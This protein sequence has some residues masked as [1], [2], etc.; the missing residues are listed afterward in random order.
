MDMQRENLAAT[1][2][3][4]DMRTHLAECAD[5]VGTARRV[6]GREHN[7]TYLGHI[8]LQLITETHICLLGKLVIFLIYLKRKYDLLG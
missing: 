4:S 8:L 5:G 3:G 1:S 6:D 7:K 2:Y